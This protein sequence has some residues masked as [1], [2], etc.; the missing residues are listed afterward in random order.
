MCSDKTF[1]LCDMILCTET[2]LVNNENLEKVFIDDFQMVV[3]NDSQHRFSSFAVYYKRNIEI[4][5]AFASNGFFVV[6]ISNELIFPLKIMV[7]L[8]YRKQDLP[9]GEFLETLRYLTRTMNIDIVVGDFNVKPNTA[10]SETLDNFKQLVHEATH[11]GGSILDH[12]YA[13]NSLLEKFDLLVNVK[14]LF[15]SDHEAVHINILKK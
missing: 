8:L 13:R 12:V 7:L 9:V 2:Q 3:N 1:T 14:S 4:R 11:I 6:E 15:F 10:L 5:E